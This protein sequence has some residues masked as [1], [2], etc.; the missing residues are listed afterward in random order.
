MLLFNPDVAKEQLKIR[1]SEILDSS[2]RMFSLEIDT[3]WRILL[4]YLIY[5]R[6]AQIPNGVLT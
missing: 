1:N 3:H 4:W 5:R 2:G 6:T